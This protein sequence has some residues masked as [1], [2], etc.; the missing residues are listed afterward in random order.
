MFFI[1]FKI[2]YAI[3]TPICNSVFLIFIHLNAV[4]NDESVYELS[5]FIVTDKE[6]KGYFSGSSTSATKANELIKNTLSMLLF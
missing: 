1:Y 3:K 4:E 5:D 2:I 6:D